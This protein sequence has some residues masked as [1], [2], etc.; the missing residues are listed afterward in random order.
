MVKLR[1][2]WLSGLSV[3]VVFACPR[4][5]WARGKGEFLIAAACLLLEDVQ[6]RKELEEAGEDGEKVLFRAG[7]E[8]WR[9]RRCTPP[10]EA[11]T[12][13]Q[14][15]FETPSGVTAVAQGGCGESGGGGDGGGSC[16]CARA[17]RQVDS[18]TRRTQCVD[19]NRS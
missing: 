6:K 8:A 13:K 19:G 9:G 14:Q 2:L 10:L 5:R 17:K 18:H 3:F 1:W 16:S 7:G 4:E 15:R 11:G 12:G